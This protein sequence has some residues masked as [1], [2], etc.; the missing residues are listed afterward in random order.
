MIAALASLTRLIK[1]ATF[2]CRE[3]GCWRRGLP[4]WEID[5]ENILAPSKGWRTCQHH[6]ELERLARLAGQKNDPKF[7]APGDRVRATKCKK[8]EECSQHGN[9]EGTLASTTYS[10]QVDLMRPVFEPAKEGDL[11]F[12]I[13]SDQG[14]HYHAIEIVKLVG[15]NNSRKD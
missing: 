13:N 5:L 4:C 6:L 9:H 1:R 2:R 8:P 11:I 7:I 12:H 15:E 3:E 10:P 14:V